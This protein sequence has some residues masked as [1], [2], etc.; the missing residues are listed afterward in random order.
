MNVHSII[1]KQYI[2]NYIDAFLFTKSPENGSPLLEKMK[3]LKRAKK[4]FVRYIPTYFRN[5]L[6]QILKLPLIMVGNQK[7]CQR[8]MFF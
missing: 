1:L 8:Q 5:Y 2:Y 6:R 4:I 3:N 7:H